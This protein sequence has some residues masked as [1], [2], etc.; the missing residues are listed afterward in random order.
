MQ[1]E[2]LFIRNMQN[3]KKQIQFNIKISFELLKTIK[4]AK[5]WYSFKISYEKKY[6][7]RNYLYILNQNLKKIDQ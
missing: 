5:I 2:I 1:F 4:K 7:F 3:W 6:I